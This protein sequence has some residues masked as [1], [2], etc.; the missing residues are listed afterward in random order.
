METPRILC[1]DD[2]KVPLLM[3]ALVLE[4]AGFQVLTSSSGPE[5]LSVLRT[6]PID[7][8]LSDQLMPE[9]TGTE[10]A[11]AIKKEFKGIPVVILSGVN[12]LPDGMEF[13]DLF[14]SKLDGPTALCQ[15][16]SEMV[17]LKLHSELK[18]FRN[19]QV[20]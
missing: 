6:R 12:E 18:G 9:M 10:L 14:L 17:T 15:R 4:K 5:A 8:V 19:S 13:V 2:E 11:R 3:R 20:C 1:V 7:V 16:L